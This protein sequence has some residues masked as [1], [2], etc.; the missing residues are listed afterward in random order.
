MGSPL[1]L[2]GPLGILALP[3]AVPWTHG[4]TSNHFKMS[5]AFI[6]SIKICVHHVI[7]KWLPQG[8]IHDNK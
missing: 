7:T 4:T 5:Y 1:A 6:L 2:L 3:L 8:P